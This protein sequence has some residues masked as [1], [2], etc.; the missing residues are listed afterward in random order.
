APAVEV[1]ARGSQARGEGRGRRMS[2]VRSLLLGGSLVVALAA[3]PTVAVFEG[4]ALT[5]YQDAVKVSTICAGHTSTAAIVK[6]RNGEECKAIL[7]MELLEYNGGLRQCV[8]R[9]MPLRVEIAFTSAVYNLGVA[10]IC[11][12][13]TGSLLKDGQW[14]AACNRL[15]L[16]DKARIA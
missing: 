14:D 13:Q 2:A 12:S 8:G 7:T 11:N 9:E 1:E 15:P 16:W 5:T 4:T 10:A 3:V 6:E